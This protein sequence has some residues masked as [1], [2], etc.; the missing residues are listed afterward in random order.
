MKKILLIGKD[1]QIGW[2]LQRTLDSLGTVH[3]CGHRDFDLAGPDAMR[4]FVR[5]LRPS[6][7]VNASGFTAVDKAEVDR[8]LAMQIN[9][10]APGILAEEAKHIGAFFVHYSTDYVFDGKAKTPYKEKDP[11]LPLNFYGKTK[12]AGEEAV[13]A[14]GGRYLILRT[15]WVY[16]LRGKNFLN[17]ML[18]LAR[19]GQEI[20]VVGDQFGSP[21]WSRLIA[22][23][24][25]LI[26]AQNKDHIGI[27]NLSAAGETSWY[28]FAEAI[29]EI[30]KSVQ[31]KSLVSIP[32][33]QYP[34]KVVRPPY[35][36]LNNDKVEK[37]FGI[38]LSDWKAALRLCLE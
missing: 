37:D 36:V 28:G 27:Y 17:T 18:Q 7:I 6:L 14:M 5:T 23:A 13:Q 11:T 30:M 10:V 8:E 2:E 20:K 38:A 3:A 24:T 19:A 1:G 25:A 16:G 31:P 32:S 21:T 22:E 34:S 12:L 4:A 15:S 35:S 26:L 29:F 9:A 33:S